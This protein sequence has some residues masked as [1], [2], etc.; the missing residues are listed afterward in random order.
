MLFNEKN[1]TRRANRIYQKVFIE[2]SM[3]KG[4]EVQLSREEYLT[5][6]KWIKS[7]SL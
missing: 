3:P 7:Q 4:D 5:L 1:M 2:R 6:K